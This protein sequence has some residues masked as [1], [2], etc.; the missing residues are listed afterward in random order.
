MLENLNSLSVPDP[1]LDL[2][3]QVKGT[4]ISKLRREATIPLTYA[5]T[6]ADTQAPG[7]HL[8]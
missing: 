7:S 8:K 3:L 2:C 4:D 5:I 6:S 1:S